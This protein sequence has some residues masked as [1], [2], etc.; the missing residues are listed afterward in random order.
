[1]QKQTIGDVM[2]PRPNAVTLL[3]DDHERLRRLFGEF[4]RCHDQNETALCAELASVI[5][6]ELAVHLK[7]KEEF[8]YPA[9]RDLVGHPRLIDEAEVEHEVLRT[10]AA[11]VRGGQGDD[12]RWYAAMAVLGRYVR[13]HTDDEEREL[14]WLMR[15]SGADLEA[16]GER[17]KARREELAGQR[18]LAHPDSAKAMPA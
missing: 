7:L 12:P 8:F 17:M 9:A 14:F 15:R 4:A 18:G 3:A 2:F 13:L 6:D 11:K 5:G 10:L 16:L 1:M